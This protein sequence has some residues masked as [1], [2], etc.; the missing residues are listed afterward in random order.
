M[1]VSVF[2]FLLY[3]NCSCVLLDSQAGANVQRS[4]GPEHKVHEA[5]VLNE[6]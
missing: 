6:L 4:Y 5:Q 1:Q 3:E 2:K